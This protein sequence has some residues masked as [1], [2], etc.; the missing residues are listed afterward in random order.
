MGF[1]ALRDQEFQPLTLDPEQDAALIA[2]RAKLA[3]RNADAFGADYR[4]LS[5]KESSVFS[6][7]LLKKNPDQVLDYLTT[8]FDNKCVNKTNGL[9]ALLKCIMILCSTFILSKTKLSN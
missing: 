9:I 1:E 7:T 8:L 6:E 4:L 5:N 3:Q 2:Q